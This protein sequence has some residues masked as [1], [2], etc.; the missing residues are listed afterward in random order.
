MPPL[1]SLHPSLPKK[2]E[3]FNTMLK[4]MSASNVEPYLPYLPRRNLAGREFGSP[5]QTLNLSVHSEKLFAPTRQVFPC[6]FVIE[7][8]KSEKGR[9]VFFWGGGVRFYLFLRFDLILGEVTG[10]R[11]WRG[12]KRCLAKRSVMDVTTM[13][14]SNLGHPGV[15][16]LDFGHFGVFVF[17]FVRSVCGLAFLSVVLFIA[18]ILF[19]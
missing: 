14:I 11:R 19:F 1:N 7:R 5:H 13:I 12:W 9:R 4:S 6:L 16:D 10:C 8:R 18:M 3:T 17:R 2:K 15:A